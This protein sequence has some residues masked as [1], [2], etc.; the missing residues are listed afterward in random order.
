VTLL[1]PERKIEMA[2]LAKRTFID[3]MGLFGTKSRLW[4]LLMELPMTI[5]AL[6]QGF[7]ET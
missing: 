3:S 4:P 1:L 2:S 6:L 5:L 7:Q